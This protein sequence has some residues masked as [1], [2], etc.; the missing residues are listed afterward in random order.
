[1]V[2]MVMKSQRHDGSFPKRPCQLAL[3]SRRLDPLDSFETLFLRSVAIW[4]RV[5][6]LLSVWANTHGTG[7]LEQCVL[8][9][10]SLRL[11]AGPSRREARFHCL[12][13]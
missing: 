5:H 12:S 1:M 4:E 6:R 3:Q 7:I 13:Q 8:A 11:Q 2:R 9:N 10:M